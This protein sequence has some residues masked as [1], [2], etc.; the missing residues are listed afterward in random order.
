M[1]ITK[2]NINDALIIEPK[3]YSDSRGTFY[4]AWNLNK[5]KDLCF[6]DLNFVQENQ[7]SSMF[8]VLRG[9]HYQ[10]KKPQGK[11]VRV[12]H[13]S[14]LDVIVDLRKSSTSFG[15]YFSIELSGDNKKQLWIPPGLAHG[16][17]T[18]KNNTE[19]IYQTTEY[20]DPHDEHTI[21][22]G[23]QFLNIDWN[24]KGTTPLMSNKD[25]NGNSF[26]EAK[27]YD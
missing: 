9:L 17:L 25:M 6:L 7:S 21:F 24:L 11:L 1:K 14:V 19:F 16:F 27:Y 18:L 2:I 22:W 13:G 3:V 4:E 23:D 20:Y 5:L 12:A 15:K 8:G 10:L 26:L